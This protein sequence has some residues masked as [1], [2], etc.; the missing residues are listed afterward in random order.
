MSK[1]DP[2][3]VGPYAK[4]G[5]VYVVVETPAGSRTKYA[6]DPDAGAFQAKRVLPL[7]MAFPYDFGFIPRT[8]AEDGDPLDALVL[9]DA[10]LVTGSLV[11]CRVLGAFEVKQSD[12]GKQEMVRNDRL[13]VAPTFTLRGAEW[14][15]LSDVGDQL[16]AEIGA[17]FKSYVERQGRKYEQLGTVQHA[18]A[19]KI[20]EKAAL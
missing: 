12:V 5:Y 6:W 19:L 16:I 1:H 8:R 9:A 4:A 7:G 13:I 20:V 10:P 2:V 14:R 3:H 17:F 18:T 15:T 11:T